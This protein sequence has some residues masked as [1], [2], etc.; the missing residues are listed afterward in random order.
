M[1]RTKQI[2]VLIGLLCI[3]ALSIGIPQTS[4]YNQ[5]IEVTWIVPG[6]T[7]FAYNLAGSETEIVFDTSGQNFSGVS[8]RSQTVATAGLTLT[9]QGNKAIKIDAIFDDAWYDAGITF[10]NMSLAGNN[11]DTLFYWTNANETS[12]NLTI[13]ASLAT[14][15]S[16]EYWIYSSGST[17]GE[18]AEGADKATFHLTSSAA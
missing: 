14:S 4:A 3:T 12:S 11:N 1:K 5:T 7:T 17:V 13:I 9:N 10:F 8:M 6:D 18:S 2:C 15:T 16:E